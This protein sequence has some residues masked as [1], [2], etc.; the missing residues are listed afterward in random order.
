MCFQNSKYVFIMCSLSVIIF[1]KSAYCIITYLK[2][3]IQWFLVS[4]S[5]VTQLCPTL[6]NPMD[7]STPGFPVHHQLLEPTQ[8]HVHQ[9]GDAIQPSHPLLSHSPPAFNVSHYQS[10]FKWV[11]SV[12][13]YPFLALSFLYSP[14][15]TSTRDYWKNHRFD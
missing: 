2:W 9:V 1:R 11:C 4:V 14:T 12:Q 15:L 6:C 10:L 8:S 13:K 7:C 5:S 3:L